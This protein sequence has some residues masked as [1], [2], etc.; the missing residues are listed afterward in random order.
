MPDVRSK[1]DISG[2]FNIEADEFLMLRKHCDVA[3]LL[4]EHLNANGGSLTINWQ[5]HSW[6]G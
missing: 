1:R 2:V 3:S 5:L 4:S 6:D